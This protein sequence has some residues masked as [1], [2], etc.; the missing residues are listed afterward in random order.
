MSFGNLGS[1]PLSAS[2]SN[3]HLEHFLRYNYPIINLTHPTYL[4]ER[5]SK[6]TCEPALYWSVLALASLACSHCADCRDINVKRSLVQRA[7]IELV[8]AVRS[9]LSRPWNGPVEW[10]SRVQVAAALFLQ[11]GAA[12]SVK[13]HTSIERLKVPLEVLLKDQTGLGIRANEPR[14]WVIDGGRRWIE[15]DE[16]LR[17]FWLPRNL[18]LWVLLLR[19]VICENALTCSFCLFCRFG[20]DLEPSKVSQPLS[21]NTLLPAGADIPAK[22]VVFESIHPEARAVT[23]PAHHRV[24]DLFTWI[25][26]SPASDPSVLALAR[27]AVPSTLEAG[28]IANNS[29]VASMMAM[30]VEFRRFSLRNN[31]TWTM[32]RN[33]RKMGAPY[34]AD[35]VGLATTELERINW[36]LDTY[37]SVMPESVQSCIIEGDAPALCAIFGSSWGPPNR[38]KFASQMLIYLSFQCVAKSHMSVGREAGIAEAMG[39]QGMG[40]KSRNQTGDSSEDEESQIRSTRRKFEEEQD[41][42]AFV[43]SQE[44]LEATRYAIMGTQLV[45]SLLKVNSKP[46]FLSQFTAVAMLR[47]G[48]VHLLAFKTLSEAAKTGSAGAGDRAAREAVLS[49]E[50]LGV[51]TYVMNLAL[52]FV[53]FNVHGMQLSKDLLDE[54]EKVT[55]TVRDVVGSAGSL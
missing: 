27:T 21:I 25:A 22:D 33:R 28:S 32:L 49:N 48:Y 8:I 45:R 17:V 55:E 47:L 42:C 2:C 41:E 40:A 14:Q 13:N 35:P 54:V 11:L 6:G 52:K 16:G 24:A 3:A 39:Q 1:S 5:I 12:F 29:L 36:M 46:M 34:G 4:Q 26:T 38:E 43:E 31:I 53:S 10:Y 20:R 51:C 50:L 30:L 37:L 23:C 7:G 9:A 18:A 15:W 44:F 19:H